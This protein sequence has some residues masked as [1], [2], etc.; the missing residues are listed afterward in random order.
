VQKESHDERTQAF[1]ACVDV[2]VNTYAKKSH[3][4]LTRTDVL[5]FL[6][7]R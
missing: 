7:L 2:S 3:G 5:R 1:F 6:Y 4:E